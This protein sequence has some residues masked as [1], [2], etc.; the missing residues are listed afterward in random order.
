M[1]DAPEPAIGAGTRR[2][3]P[4][5]SAAALLI[6]ATGRVADALLVGA[7]VVFVYGSVPLA[8]RLADR[9]VP[10]THRIWI[11]LAFSSFAA[12]V[13]SLVAAIAWPILVR[14]QALYLGAIPLCLMASGLFE[15]SE[16][17][18]PLELIHS[19]LR[20]ALSFAAAALAF[21][22]VR[23]P[24]SYGTISLPS[25][26]GI[27]ILFG[28]AEASD[29]SFRSL[30]A[31]VGGFLLLGYSMALFRWVRFR[32]FGSSPSGEDEE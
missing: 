25:A 7:A 8:L 14:E 17:Q 1:K 21:S 5:F 2:Q 13:F 30:A 15:R 11:R 24:L 9:A 22:L 4:S 32:R 27:S 6:A 16:I 31:T 10:A 28:S 19:S 23:E 3:F 26:T 18:S 12:A 20:E 29:F